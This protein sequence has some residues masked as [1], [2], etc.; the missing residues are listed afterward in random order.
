MGKLSLHGH[1][2]D[3]LSGAGLNSYCID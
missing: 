2:T 1:F 3:M